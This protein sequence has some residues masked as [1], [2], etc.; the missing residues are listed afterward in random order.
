MIVTNLF[1]HV[2][3][4]LLS[5]GYDVVI[6]LFF[7]AETH[8][9]K[10][11]HDA[12][13]SYEVF[14]DAGFKHRSSRCTPVSKS[15]GGSQSPSPD[16]LDPIEGS[17]SEVAGEPTVIV[18]EDDSAGVVD[19][20][21]PV[22]ST[23]DEDVGVDADSE[24]DGVADVAVESPS[25]IDSADVA[26]PV[27]DAPVEDSAAK[28]EAAIVEDDDHVEESPAGL[29][30]T[31]N[32]AEELTDKIASLSVRE[33]VEKSEK[34]SGKSSSK[35]HRRKSKS[36][37]KAPKKFGGGGVVCQACE[38]RV[39]SADKQM[40]VSR[41]YSAA[42]FT[43]WRARA[44]ARGVCVCVCVTPLMLTQLHSVLGSHMARGVLYVQSSGACRRQVIFG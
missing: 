26:T 43:L 4:M 32:D 3:M 7:D 39:Y 24:G 28:K 35:G 18:D 34:S 36:K 21:P 38:K 13:G 41:I 8:F 23:A 33:F 11:F 29:T 44:R 14:G 42:S 20:V 10:A 22:S 37:K 6:T 27:E 30:V 31:G 25:E 2:I 17:D 19:S 1:P 9:I 15:P 12:G 16:V 40:S 5:Y